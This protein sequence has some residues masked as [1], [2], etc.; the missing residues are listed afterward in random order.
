VSAADEPRALHL[1]IHGHVQGVFFR[2][3]LR[4]CA[5]HNDV[6]GWV[7]N[8]D[9]GAVEAHLE[10]APEDVE[11]V[12]AFARRGPSSAAVRDVDIRDSQPE[13]LADFQVR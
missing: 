1:V 6:T 10:G 13:E 5:E 8:R 9:D 2:D 11:T 3:S 12:L 7:A 4:E